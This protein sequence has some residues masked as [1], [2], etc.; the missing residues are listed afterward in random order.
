MF[1]SLA[2]RSPCMVVAYK[3][4]VHIWTHAIWIWKPRLPSAPPKFLWIPIEKLRATGFPAVLTPSETSSRIHSS[5]K[6]LGKCPCSWFQLW[7]TKDK[8]NELQRSHVWRKL[9][10]KKL[11]WLGVPSFAVMLWR[12]PEGSQLSSHTHVVHSFFEPC[13]LLRNGCRGKVCQRNP[14]P[15]WCRYEVSKYLDMVRFCDFVKKI[16]S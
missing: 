4:G 6:H 15:L 2:R 3:R 7:A 11:S 9:K 16:L 5:R 10:P 12:W 8:H 14:L 13:L 1:R